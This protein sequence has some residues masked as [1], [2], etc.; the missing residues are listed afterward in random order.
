MKNISS[1]RLLENVQVT[2]KLDQKHLMFLE[3]LMNHQF[4]TKVMEVINQ[5]LTL[6]INHLYLF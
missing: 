1:I 5:L 4:N 2:F 3:H 6:W